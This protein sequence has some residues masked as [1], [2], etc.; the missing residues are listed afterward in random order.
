MDIEI[1]SLTRTFLTRSWMWKVRLQKMRGSNKVQLWSNVAS[2]G[3]MGLGS[4]ALLTAWIG[5]QILV[6]P[7]YLHCILEWRRSPCSKAAEESLRKFQQRINTARCKRYRKVRSGLDSSGFWSIASAFGKKLCVRR[8]H[9]IP[10]FRGQPSEHIHREA[11]ESSKD[12]SST[13]GTYREA[14][15]LTT[16]LHISIQSFIGSNNS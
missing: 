9:Q 1:F 13:E 6:E 16:P 8:I 3:K 10:D 2:D 5:L 4:S 7:F 12:S 14:G 11:P 15:L